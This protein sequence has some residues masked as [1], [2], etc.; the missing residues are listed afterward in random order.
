M[1]SFIASYDFAYDLYSSNKLI[2][3]NHQSHLS[4]FSG[5]ELPGLI[6]LFKQ[7]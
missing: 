5:E 2:E 1:F 4:W 3:I 6:H 7:D